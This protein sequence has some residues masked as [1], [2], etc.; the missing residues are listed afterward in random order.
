VRG[1]MIEVAARMLN[2]APDRLRCADRRISAPDGRS[3]TISEVALHSLHVEN[4]R[5]IMATASRMSYDSP[6][7]F[8]AQFA[9]VEVDTE[10]G[11]V[12][13]LKAVSAVD[14]G[15][16]INP[17]TA[18]GQIEGG[19][20]QAMGYGVCEEMVYDGR[21]ALLT[22]DLQRYH[23]YSAAEMPAMQTFLVE[24]SDPYGPFGAKAVAEIPLDSMAPAIANAVA[25]AIGVR[26]REIPLTPERVLRAIKEL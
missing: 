1:Q 23:I 20:T 5:Q 19:T 17:A 11:E 13:V 21:G 22:T 24:T 14:C 18:E 7:P 16:A 25:N 15:R 4:Q 26:V 10:T 6:P 8:A 12:R 3:V 9:E 2:T